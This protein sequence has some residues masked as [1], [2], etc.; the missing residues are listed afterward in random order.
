MSACQENRLTA[1]GPKGRSV[2]GQ[3]RPE[4]SQGISYATAMAD[5]RTLIVVAVNVC[6]GSERDIGEGRLSAKNE[7]SQGGYDARKKQLENLLYSS[8]LPFIKKETALI[9]IIIRIKPTG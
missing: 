9:T 1:S 6:S 2:F 3:Q 4:S 8:G 7:H 5:Y